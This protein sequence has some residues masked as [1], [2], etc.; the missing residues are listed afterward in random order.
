MA[1]MTAPQLLDS[2]KSPKSAVPAKEIDW[3]EIE[4]GLVLLRVTACEALLE[5]RA[6]LPKLKEVGLGESVMPSPVKLIT[7]GLAG[8]LSLIV[9]LPERLPRAWGEK[10]MLI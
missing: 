3:R 6:I 2:M 1:A 5:P 7:W 8:S 4:L 10:V 9:M